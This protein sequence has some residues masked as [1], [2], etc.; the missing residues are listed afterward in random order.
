MATMNESD[1]G[2][3]KRVIGVG[4]SGNRLAFVQVKMLATLKFNLTRKQV[5]AFRYRLGKI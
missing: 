5:R 2:K 4:R 1:D 3:G